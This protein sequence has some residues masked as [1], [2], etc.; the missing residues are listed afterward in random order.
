[1]KKKAKQTNQLSGIYKTLSGIREE[2]PERR[3]VRPEDS[4]I[5]PNQLY[6]S[7]G[8]GTNVLAKNGKSID[9]YQFGGD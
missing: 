8:V 9:S 3:Y 7:T 6:P 2:Q 5:N 4:L 1:M